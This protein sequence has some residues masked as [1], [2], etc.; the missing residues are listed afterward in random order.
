MPVIPTGLQAQTCELIQK[1]DQVLVA[2]K[3]PKQASL[4]RVIEMVPQLNQA[5]ITYMDSLPNIS[6][7]PWEFAGGGDTLERDM[8]T[9][10]A[11][12][13][14]QARAAAINAVIRDITG[15]IRVE[16]EACE[17]TAYAV[18]ALNKT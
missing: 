12:E 8:D 7:D 3:R 17:G 6:L 15:A 9:A 1:V 10:S 16:T 18:A 4:L 11:L 14:S 5:Y 13:Y 2:L